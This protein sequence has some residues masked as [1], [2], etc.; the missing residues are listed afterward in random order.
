LL[1][2]G[3]TSSEMY[4][5]VILASI[6][7]PT[8]MFERDMTQIMTNTFNPFV[9][10]VLDPNMDL[11]II[12]DEYSCAAYV[13]EYVNKSNRGISHLHTEL[14]KVQEESPEITEDA[15]M[16]KIALKMLNA[17]EMSAQEAAWYLL[18][19]PMS[20]ASR[21]VFYVPTVWPHERQ[22]ARKRLEQMEEEGIEA[23]STDVWTTGPIQRFEERPESMRDVCLADF[24]AGRCLAITRSRRKG[25]IRAI[26]M[27]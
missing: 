20:Y 26:W 17:V 9:S 6:V 11:Q 1:D 14:L 10:S 5:D 2:N 25:W 21:D 4:A 18:R 19:Q 16:K 27:P 22:K 7:R 12:L 24:L 15:L 23:T 3:I 8:I 13:V